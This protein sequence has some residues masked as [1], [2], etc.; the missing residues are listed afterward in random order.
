MK[1]DLLLLGL[2]IFAMARGARRGAARQLGELGAALAAFYFARPLAHDL[3]PRLAEL[4]A[5]PPDW[6]KSGVIVLSAIVIFLAT[7]AVLTGLFRYIV[8][9]ARDP[10][11]GGRDRFLGGILG[12]LKLAAVAYLLL[13]AAMQLEGGTKL[14]GRSSALLPEDSRAVELARRHNFFEAWGARATRGLP[15]ALQGLA[16]EALLQRPFQILQHGL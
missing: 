15:S 12:G 6:S 2:M 1:L 14:L 7:R 5:L 13:S 16:P 3:E 9:D 4:L 8:S 11:G 10:E